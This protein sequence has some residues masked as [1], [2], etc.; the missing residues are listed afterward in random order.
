[1]KNNRESINILDYLTEEQLS[2]TKI[3]KIP[4]ENKI[5]LSI[6]NSPKENLSIE[7]YEQVL[8]IITVLLSFN[9]MFSVSHQY[10][11]E[12]KGIHHID[13]TYDDINS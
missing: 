13:I 6:K 12:K 7:V 8:R 4:D 3:I 9:M 2:R 10:K 1:M 11:N 5:C